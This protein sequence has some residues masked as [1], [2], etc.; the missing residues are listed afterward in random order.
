MGPGA[1]WPRARVRV[2]QKSKKQIADLVE[3]EEAAGEGCEG[4]FRI[5]FE[6]SGCLAKS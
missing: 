6:S 5:Y 2:N 4:N 1:C 3:Q